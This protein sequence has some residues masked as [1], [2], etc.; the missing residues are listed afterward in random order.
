VYLFAST[1]HADAR[2]LPA[3]GDPAIDGTLGAQPPN[4]LDY[5]PLLR[6]ALINL[7]RWV[8]DGVEP[9][10]SRH[11]R[12]DDGSAVTR[13]RSLASLPPIPGMA[14]PDPERLWVLR[15]TDM[16]PDGDSGAGRYPVTEGR[17]YP[18]H[19]SALDGDGNEVAGIRLPGV[20]VPLGT[21]TGWNPRHADSG[22]PDQIIPMRGFTLYFPRNAAEREAT[23]DPRR[24][25]EERYASRDAYL[26]LARE[27]A[28]ELARQRYVLDED[29]DVLVADCARDYDEAMNGR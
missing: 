5:R 13:A 7:D 23:G 20:S 16:G 3:P 9:P 26:A 8:S 2:Q 25:I 4:V 10:P 21:H 15:E 17:A 27:Q 22:A 18:S 12:L 6:A 28:Q 1:Q 11:P 19:V 29:V 24:S 14:T